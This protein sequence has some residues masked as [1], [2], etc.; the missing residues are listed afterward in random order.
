MRFG[1]ETEEFRVHQSCFP[2]PAA[3]T[4]SQTA[5]RMEFIKSFSNA[6]PWRSMPV[7]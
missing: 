7:L 6:M 4:R 5:F 2:I 1:G 3:A